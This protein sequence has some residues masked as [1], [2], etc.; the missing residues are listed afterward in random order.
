MLVRGENY[1]QFR[2]CVLELIRELRYNMAVSQTLS[3]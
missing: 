2:F 1:K 3:S